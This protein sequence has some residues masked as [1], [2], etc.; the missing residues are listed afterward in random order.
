MYDVWCSDLLFLFVKNSHYET[1]HYAMHHQTNFQNILVCKKK[2]AWCKRKKMNILN[3]WIKWLKQ[4]VQKFKLN[5]SVRNIEDV[6]FIL[7]QLIYLF[8]GHVMNS[9]V[10]YQNFCWV[11]NF[12]IIHLLGKCLSCRTKSTINALHK[13]QKIFTMIS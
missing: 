11:G 9:F 1:K 6:T 10:M 7:K 2:K 5:A 13:L 12:C 8:H 4:S 3:K